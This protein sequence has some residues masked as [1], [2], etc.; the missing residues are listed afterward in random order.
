MSN[1]SLLNRLFSLKG[2]TAL[3]TGASGG[4]GRALAVALG[5][6]GAAVGVHGRDDADLAET[7]K[8]VDAAGGR[9]VILKA[10]IADVAACRRL[11]D[12]T[13]RQLGRLDV[14]VNCAGINFR[15]PLADAT[16]DEFEKI[17]AVNLRGLF[18]LCQAAYPVMKAQGGG[19]IV[20]V[21]SI[22][23]TWGLGG[24]GV[25]GMTKSAVG[26]LT[27][28][29]AVEWAADN[30]QVNCLAPGF[31][32]TPLTAESVWGV[33]SRR[34]WMMS[35]IPAKRPGKPEDMVTAVLFMAA[36][37]SSYLTGQTIA[38]DGGVM[39]GGSW[40]DR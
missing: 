18:F 22:T 4:I 37:G 10:D 24:V 29:L 25:Y 40:D 39:A 31:I 9:G 23:T 15:N 1:D 17:F 28:T 35:R 14:L 13:V 21:G 12:D 20:N 33:E 30:I 3:V 7:R 32:K 5:G 19:K 27:R 16:E 38:V 26:H 6:A 11:T 2:K 8:Q 34:E 36:P